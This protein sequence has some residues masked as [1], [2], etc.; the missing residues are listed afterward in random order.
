MNFLA[1]QAQKFG[2]RTILF[3]KDRGAELFI[4]G[5][6]GRYRP[7]SPRR[8][9]RLQP[10]RA[11]RQRRATARSCA[12]GSACCSRPKGPRSWRRSP[13]RSTRLTPTIPRCAACAISAS[14]SS[15]ARRPEAGRPRRRA[16]PVDRGRRA[17]LAVRQRR[18]QARPVDAHARLRH[19]RAA[20]QPA[21]AHAGDDVPVPPH[22]RAARRRSRR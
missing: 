3:D 2:P 18:R 15:G 17:R 12:T 19:D 1:A 4:R 21:P 8:A 7:H 10:A 6:G 14:C 22:R 5:I 9:D 13:A 11:A 20:R 16:R